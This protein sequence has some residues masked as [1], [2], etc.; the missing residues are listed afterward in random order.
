MCNEQARVLGILAQIAGLPSRYIG[1]MTLIDYDNVRSG[2]GHGV[3]EIYVEGKWAYFDIRGR[4]FQN[5]DGT[6]ASTWDI[7]RDPGLID[8]QPS[9]VLAHRC[10][11]ADHTVAARYYHPQSVTIVANYLAADHAR[12]DY[13]WVYPS[14]SLAREAREAGRRRQASR[15]GDPDLEPV[16]LRRGRVGPHLRDVAGRSRLSPRSGR[17]V[18]AAR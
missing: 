11:R 17:L 3:N 2:T 10:P 4:Y 15:R 5:D 9:E 18:N 12:Y 7:L 14:E 1:H 6:L 16:E 8:R 13:A